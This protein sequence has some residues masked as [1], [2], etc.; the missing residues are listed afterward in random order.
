M[1][2]ANVNLYSPVTAQHFKKIAS[3]FPFLVNV[4]LK[5]DALMEL[6]V[7]N[8]VSFSQGFL[9]HPQPVFCMIEGQEA[10]KKRN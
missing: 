8:C 5:I 10:T 4:K 7:G 9:P 3:S 2:G 6:L 1:S